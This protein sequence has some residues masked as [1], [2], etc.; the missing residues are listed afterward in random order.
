MI[1]R[2]V[3]AGG[4]V[5]CRRVFVNI[6]SVFTRIRRRESAGPFLLRRFILG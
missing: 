6:P 1:R 2:L 5:A 4:D 3:T